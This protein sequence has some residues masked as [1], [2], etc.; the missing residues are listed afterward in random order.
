MNLKEAISTYATLVLENKRDVIDLINNLGLDSL[1]YDSPISEVN[2]IVIENFG[3][4]DFI[5]GIR[6]IQSE[7]YSNVVVID[8]I[9]YIIVFIIV[10]AGS[11][12]A[13]IISGNR[14][15]RMI[16]QEMIREGYRSGYLKKEE[17]QQIAYLE[18]E[19]LQILFLNA[20]SDYL[21]TKE[22]A[23]AKAKNYKNEQMV[24]IVGVGVLAVILSTIMIK[25]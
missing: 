16:R 7:G 8:D 15:A 14:N 24:L 13:K 4:D 25:D 3:N 2:K 11:A 20:Q 12:T 22:E 19:R 6:R 5:S 1:Q 23:E 21:R 10:V 17:L 9:V 18:R